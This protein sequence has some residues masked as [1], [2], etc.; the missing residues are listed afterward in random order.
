MKYFIVFYVFFSINCSAQISKV[1]VADKGDGTYKNP[2]IHADYSD[3]DAIRVGNDYY[4]VSSSFNFVP[5]LPILHS[6]DLVNWEL[7]GHALQNLSY[8]ERFSKVQNGGGVWAPSIRFHE[9]KFYI[10]FPDPDEGIFMIC[11]ADILGPWS[12][13]VLVL[14]GKGLIDP[15]PLWDDDSKAYLVYALA[16]SRAGVKSVL[17]LQSLE[18]DGTKVKDEPILLFDG[19]KDHPTVE[20]PKIYKQN[21]YYYISA[22]AGG[23]ATGWQLI[24]RSKNIY[25]PYES[26]VVLHQGETAING[27]HQGAW[28]DTPNGDWWFIHF[29]DKDAYGRVVHL[30]PVTWE[31]GWPI[32]GTDQNKDGIGE[33][34]L[35]HAKPKI[36]SKNLIKTP[37][38]NDE[39]DKSKTGLQ[40]QWPA[41]REIT[42]AMPGINGFYRLNTA[43]QEGTLFDFPNMM[44]QKFPAESFTA[45]TKIEVNFN[46]KL[47]TEKIGFIVRG[48]RSAYVALAKTKIGTELVYGIQEN[49][50]I[51]E[52][53]IK[54]MSGIT[55]IYFRIKVKQ[56]AG[57][58][59]FYSFDGVNFEKVN[60]ESF[61][62]EPGLWVGASIGYFASRKEKTNDS[63]YANIDWFRIEP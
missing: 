63:G 57:C 33:P 5:G 25:G 46:E 60:N 40:W 27:P 8:S 22:P 7:V 24:L 19:H 28:V 6:K 20:G 16:G 41:N 37:I 2:I 21:G 59:F 51:L 15:C 62:A 35:E 26:R 34:V 23:V 54:S 43:L 38:E 3:P 31:N 36:S 53:S 13:P 42:Y 58:D 30:Q 48:K 29:Q 44:L 11:S 18:T 56:G 1:W 52:T 49:G 45:T 61:V 17:L 10:F 14:K 4:M 32:M 47:H 55:Q 12:E 9:Q 50:E 39:F